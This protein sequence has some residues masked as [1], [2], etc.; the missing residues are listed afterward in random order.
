MEIPAYTHDALSCLYY[1]RQMPTLLP[2]KSVFVTIHHDKKNYEVEVQVEA[3]ETI[4]GPWG[5]VEVI[6]LL[7]VMP[8]RGIFLNEGNIRLW[9]TNDF[10]RVPVKMKARVIVGSVEAVLENQLL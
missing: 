7:A 4:S 8:F 10:R 5:N 9:L 6:R 1:L 2:G 3:I